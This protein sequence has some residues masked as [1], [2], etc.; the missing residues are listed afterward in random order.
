MTASFHKGRLGVRLAQDAADLAACQA[1]RHACF[2]GKPGVDADDFDAVC[3]HIMIGGEGGLVGTCRVMVLQDGAALS[4]SYA[5]TA[6]DLSPLAAFERPV[7]EIGRF[8]VTP[9]AGTVDV[10]RLA[11]GALT[12]LV[13]AHGA[14]MLI[15]CSSFAGADPQRHAPA[16][17]LLGAHHQGPDALRPLRRAAR[18]VS[19]AGAV[20]DR[21]AALAGLP[22][23]LRSYLGMG[24]WVGDHAVVDDV[25]DTVHVFTAVAVDAVPPARARALRALAG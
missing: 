6:Y 8:C 24:G 23:L 9:T 7:M 21:R 11:W 18:T 2:F 10:L 12:G 1:L 22:Q 15:G 16:L 25:M 17:A 13:D 19:L 4:A 20:P 5:A 14:G 3:Q